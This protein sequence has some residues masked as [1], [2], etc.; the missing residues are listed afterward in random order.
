MNISLTEIQKDALKKVFSD[1]L[2][3][4]TRSVVDPSWGDPRMTLDELE[5]A[6]KERDERG[7]QIKEDQKELA[8]LEIF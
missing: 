4:T 3:N 6:D 8:Y 1:W 5:R 7:K 2:R